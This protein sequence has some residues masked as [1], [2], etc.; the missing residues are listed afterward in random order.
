MI[1]NEYIYTGEILF[2]A[3]K[4][5]FNNHSAQNISFSEGSQ[6]LFAPLATGCI[7][8]LLCDNIRTQQKEQKEPELNT[9]QLFISSRQGKNQGKK[10]EMQGGNTVALDCR[11]IYLGECSQHQHTVNDW[12]VPKTKHFINTQQ[13]SKNNH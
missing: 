2:T 5:Y 13:C 11:V 12:C 8:I 1:P 6:A 7:V 4:T 3:G 10:V 9:D